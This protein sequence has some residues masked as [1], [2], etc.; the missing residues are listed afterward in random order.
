MSSIYLEQYQILCSSVMHEMLDL[1]PNI[2]HFMCLYTDCYF[3]VFLTA[4]D[5]LYWFVLF[6]YL[7]K[8]VLS[9]CCI[10]LTLYKCGKSF[11]VYIPQKIFSCTWTK[12]LQHWNPPEVSYW[13]TTSKCEL[14]FFIPLYGVTGH[15]W[16]VL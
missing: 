12:F 7:F 2:S 11:L 16:C 5:K 8:I 1:C 3:F 9:I 15:Y 14:P 4:L 10:W 6:L 13:V